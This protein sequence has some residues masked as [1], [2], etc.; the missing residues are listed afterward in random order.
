MA[1]TDRG[2]LWYTHGMMRWP[3]S[4]MLMAVLLTAAQVNYADTLQPSSDSAATAEAPAAG[5]VPEALQGII[6]FNGTP[7]QEADYYIYLQ[8][9]SWCHP[10]CAEMPDIVAAYPAMKEKKVELILISCD[11]SVE[12]GRKF[13]ET[14]KATF[15]AIHYTEKELATLPGY[16]PARGIPDATIVDRRG[17]VVRRGHGAMVK[18]WERIIGQYEAEQSEQKAAE[19]PTQSP[20]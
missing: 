8:S 17:H 1:L 13:L 20:S 6:T 18:F 19:A 15:P 10:C 11:D 9:A 7:S 4:L 2:L 14:Y 5:S 12:S 3:G 16:T